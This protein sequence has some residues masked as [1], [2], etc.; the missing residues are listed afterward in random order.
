MRTLG[1]SAFTRR[2]CAALLLDG[3]APLAHAEEEFS[4]E[5]GDPS[6]PARAARRCPWRAGGSRHASSTRWSSSRSACAAS[7]AC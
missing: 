3:R 4:R 6:F 2:S 1:L 7:N 5:A